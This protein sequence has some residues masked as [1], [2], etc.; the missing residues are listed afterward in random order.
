M[1]QIQGEKN[2]VAPV[3]EALP[4]QGEGKRAIDIGTG[5]RYSLTDNPLTNRNWNLVWHAP[6]NVGTCT[7]CALRITE[8]AQEFPKAEWIVGI[9]IKAFPTTSW[10]DVRR[11]W[12]SCQ[13]SVMTF[14]T[15]S[16]L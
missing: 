2:Y 14:R 11:V 6:D 12:T 3:A 15:M 5:K 10:T 4:N 9:L 7:H 16:S 8:M 1:A 13:F